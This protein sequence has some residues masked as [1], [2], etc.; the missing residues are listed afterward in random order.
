MKKKENHCN[1]LLKIIGDYR[2]LTIITALQKGTLRFCELQRAAGNV[3]P[4]T[5]TNRLKRLEKIG[6]VSRLKSTEDKLA[7]SYTLTHHGTSM[8]PILKDIDALAKKL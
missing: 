7:V 3:N 4:V 2:T 1:A 6:F 8:I 5:L